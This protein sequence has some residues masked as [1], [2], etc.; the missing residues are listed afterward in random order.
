MG[1]S[2]RNMPRVPVCRVSA[3]STWGFCE[4]EDNTQAPLAALPCPAL[5][6]SYLCNIPVL[7]HP[8]PVLPAVGLCSSHLLLQARAGRSQGAAAPR[9]QS[10]SALS[11]TA[12]HTSTPTAGGGAPSQASP[13]T[14]CLPLI[15]KHPAQ[16][17]RLCSIWPGSM[18]Q[19]TLLLT[20]TP[21]RAGVCRAFQNVL[22]GSL[23]M[24]RTALAGFGQ[25]SGGQWLG[26]SLNLKLTEETSLQELT[27]S[28]TLKQGWV[29]QEFRGGSLSLMIS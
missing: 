11:P 23:Q 1:G 26:S 9:L 22:H 7:R 2:P 25:E 21:S 5:P 29:G 18:W 17:P 4:N 28:Q 27:A 19:G 12:E 3:H 16:L 15:H 24:L 8:G 6:G 20:A 13:K 10:C 14:Q